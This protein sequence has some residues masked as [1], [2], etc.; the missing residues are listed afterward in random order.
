[1]TAIAHGTKVQG[2]QAP[3]AAVRIVRATAA[4]FASLG[5]ATRVARAIELRQEPNPADLQVLQIRGPL[6]RFY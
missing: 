5:A 3:N 4:T 1:M 6:P 2:A